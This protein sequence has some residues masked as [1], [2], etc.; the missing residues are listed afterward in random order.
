MRLLLPLHIGIVRRWRGNTLSFSSAR[1]YEELEIEQ[2]GH[3][4]PGMQDTV[5]AQYD[6][7]LTGEN[8]AR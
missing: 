6:I 8:V 3:V 1:A 2:V 4:I 7:L 5:I